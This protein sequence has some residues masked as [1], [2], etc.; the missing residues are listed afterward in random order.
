MG[1]AVQ[2]DSALGIN[3]SVCGLHPNVLL[4]AFRWTV[5][6]PVGEITDKGSRQRT[7]TGPGRLKEQNVKS[8]R[9]W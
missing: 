2:V 9:T 8:H 5:I 1:R 6:H 7:E 3:C 4:V